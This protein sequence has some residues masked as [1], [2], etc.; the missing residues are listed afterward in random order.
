MGSR[1]EGITPVRQIKQGR[2]FSPS[3]LLGLVL[4]VVSTLGGYA[5]LSGA[6]DSRGVL[7]AARDLPAGTVLGSDDLVEA[8]MRL[9]DAVYDAALPTAALGEVIVRPLASGARWPRR[10]MRT[11]CWC[12]SM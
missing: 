6:G 10:S 2:K 12:A 11:R 8:R 1:V 9:D 4:L 7:V 3:F 5:Y